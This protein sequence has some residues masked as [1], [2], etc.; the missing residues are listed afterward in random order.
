MNDFNYKNLTPFKWFV[1][2]NFPFIENDFDA[3]NNYHLF[4]K[5][6]EYLN[7]TIGSMNLTGEQMENVTNAMTELQNYVNNYFEN[8]DVQDEINNK[9][10]EMV[11]DGTLQNLLSPLI[12]NKQNKIIPDWINKQYFFSISYNASNYTTPFVI[13]SKDAFNWKKLCHLPKN[14]FV[15]ESL[16]AG[17]RVY[18]ISCTFIDD[19]FYM[20]YDY[21]DKNYNNYEQLNNNYF[22]GGN[23]IGI[24][25]TKDFINW[26][27][28]N[29]NI[30]LEFKQTWA[31]EFFIDDN[32]YYISI[33]LNNG[34]DVYNVENKSGYFKHTYLLECNKNYNEILSYNKILNVDYNAIDSHIHKENNYYYLTV[35]NDLYGYIS[36]YKSNN[37]LSFTEKITDLK[38]YNKNGNLW[39]IEGGS[40]VKI[41][42]RY[43][44]FF[45]LNGWGDIT[46][47]FCSEDL[48]NWSTP[49]LLT[50]EE[51]FYHFTPIVT[52]TSID[53]ILIKL[54]EQYNY[55][56]NFIQEFIQQTIEY[57]IEHYN[58]EYFIP[59]PNTKYI[60]YCT[61]NFQQIIKPKNWFFG[62]NY[63][64]Y[65]YIVSNM[66][67]SISFKIQV[68]SNNIIELV[69]NNSLILSYYYEEYSSLPIAQYKQSFEGEI[70]VDNYTAGDVFSYEF[71]T[72]VPTKIKGVIVT[73]FY[74][75][76]LSDDK[77]LKLWVQYVGNQKFV[78]RMIANFNITPEQFKI[79]YK[80]F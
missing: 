28:W 25:R 69:G 27:S 40:L 10:N 9:L 47:F 29:L 16:I 49:N 78:V 13:Y 46:G 56:D 66:N 73:P 61:S 14:A 79:F 32:K 33:S 6:V 34:I 59:I 15:A 38:Y 5:V 24:S 43:F 71:T 64:N 37:L 80:T 55:P 63:K 20:I 11:E 2:E 76:N 52:N 8:L 77:T 39:S 42:D 68:S 12:N 65:N 36:I 75:S 26:E 35:K 70:L 54:Y 74:V 30:D 41:N 19:Y 58:M 21:I 53:N 45:D 57:N 3:I 31:P 72:N 62:G 17:N 1:L 67:G 44:V 48:I 4:S 23:R 50:T 60:F 22:L 7:N 51:K 18:D